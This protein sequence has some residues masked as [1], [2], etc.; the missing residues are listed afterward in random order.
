ME[1][2]AYEASEVEAQ[3]DEVEIEVKR[4][5]IFQV[6][7]HDLFWNI[8]IGFLD[9]CVEIPVNTLAYTERICSRDLGVLW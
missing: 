5:C 7:Y 4:L 1:E 2:E 6:I 3:G 8:L 9:E